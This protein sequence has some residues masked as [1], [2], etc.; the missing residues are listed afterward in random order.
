MNE[1]FANRPTTVAD[2]LAILRRRKW[3]VISL[4]LLAALAAYAISTTQPAL[5]QGT[6]EILVN[7]SNV[8]TAVTN[9][10]DPT[11]LDPTRFLTTE[12]TIARSPTLAARVVA[13]A[14]V[15][16][17]TPGKLLGE[18]NVSPA[19]YA[20][21]LWVSVSDSSA[22][23]AV[24]LANV[25]ATEFTRYK[26]E[27][28]TARISEVLHS[29]EARTSALKAS[30]QA[31][32]PSY[33][34]LIQYEGEL[35]TIG[36][37]L[38]NNTTVLRPAA[39]AT[40]IRP[41]P[42]RNGIL[43]GL[44]GGVVGLGLVFLAEALD[45]RVRSEEEIEEALGLP[46]LARVA[47]PPRRLRKTDEL[48][49]LAEPR[50]MDAETFRKLRASIEFANLERGARTIMVTS[51]VPREGKSTTV[52][53]LAVAL[54]RAGRRVALVDLDL[55][56]PTLHRFFRVRS[57]PGFTDVV[58]KRAT[59]NEAIRSLA[60]TAGTGSHTTERMNGGRS[61]SAGG[62]N[63]LPDVE[64]ALH[65]L[66]AGTIPPLAG[67]FLEDERIPAVL[68]ELADQFEVVLIDGPPLL[69]FGDALALSARVD[70]I[71]AVTRL[72]LVQR[73]AIHELARQL[74]SFRAD[75]LGFVL[76]GVDASDSYRYLYET[77]AHDLPRQPDRS[78]ERA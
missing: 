16:G 28:D 39:S 38:A 20:D 35:E 32:S 31:T 67:E 41:R 77:Y 15:P 78:E 42:V 50:G 51:A 56:R 47:K 36:K 48:V 44:L 12:A 71:F 69:A 17:M 54:A 25:Y 6:A 45:R 3:I 65:L 23:D 57:S 14:G 13:A 60:L 27:L 22:P 24:R 61:V 62:S 8:V 52:A 70:A 4:P 19:S 29:L 5:Y 10:S 34:T 21:L 46:L 26:T 76:T 59:A 7:R 40:K 53:N 33:A 2:Y 72:R 73:P 18:S 55:R 9:I 58:V 49:M 66:P 43:A 1:V 37:L 68:E 64:G 75:A 30:G 63:G 11:A 74:Q